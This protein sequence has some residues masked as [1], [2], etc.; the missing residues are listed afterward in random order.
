MN[1]QSQEV[2]LLELAEEVEDGMR[3]A[4]ELV[5]RL[6]LYCLERRAI[7]QMDRNGVESWRAKRTLHELDLE[8][9]RLASSN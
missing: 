7:R 3:R 1:H 5:K 6:D 4:H 2:M 8:R 9:Q